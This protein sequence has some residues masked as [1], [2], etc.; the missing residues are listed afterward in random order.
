MISRQLKKKLGRRKLLCS[1]TVQKVAD[2]W[3]RSVLN[4]FR[5]DPFRAVTDIRNEVIG[6]DIMEALLIAST[7]QLCTCSGL[8]KIVSDCAVELAA[9][10]AVN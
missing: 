4:C 7:Q 10:I 6:L 1:T 5:P 9:E 3:L 2:V 8:T